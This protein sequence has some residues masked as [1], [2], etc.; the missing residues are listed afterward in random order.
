MLSPGSRRFAVAFT[1]GLVAVTVIYLGVSTVLE[2]RSERLL[3]DRAEEIIALAAIPSEADFHQT[4]DGVRTFINDHSQTKIDAAFR[5]MI[6]DSVAFAD[7]IIAHARDPS[8]ERVHMEC[9]TRT[10]LMGRVLRRMG[11]ET[12]TIA[13][14]KTKG[15]YSSHT[16]LDVLNPETKGWETQ[17][18]DYDLYWTSLSSKKRVSLAETAEQLEDL[19]PCGR[20]VCGWDHVSRDGNAAKSLVDKLDILSVTNKEGD[21]RYSVYTT[22]ANLRQSFAI[23]GKT[24]TYCEVMAKRCRDGFHPIGHVQAGL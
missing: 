15:R 5:A 22:R 14:F 12:R 11:Y 7:G 9:S 20:S 3:Q 24:G 4:V 10:N 2:S 23:G 8:V 21:I 18:P 17:D 16:F 1:A 19:R 6:G 13:I